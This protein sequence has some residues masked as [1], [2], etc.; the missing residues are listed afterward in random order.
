MGIFERL[1]IFNIMVSDNEIS[2]SDEPIQ[3]STFK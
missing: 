3:I 1:K 2:S